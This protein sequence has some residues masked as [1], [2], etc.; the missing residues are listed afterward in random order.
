MRT[1]AAGPSP[2]DQ[3]PEAP[4]IPHDAGSSGTFAYGRDTPVE[5]RPEPS[6]WSY[7][8]RLSV[9]GWLVFSG[10]LD[11]YIVFQDQDAIRVLGNGP[12]L[13]NL[14]VAALVAWLLIK[15][16]LT[17]GAYAGRAALLFYACL[18]VVGANAA[19][20]LLSLALLVI[21]LAHHQP[22]RLVLL[23]LL[24]QLPAA[25]LFWWMVEGLRRF[26]PWAARRV[27]A[28]PA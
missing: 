5:F 10:L 15:A 11:A 8:M 26:G 1:D 27:P 22:A 2:L 13:F 24:V 6:E 17:V 23:S 20:V 18:A 12:G 7:P 19:L 14:A 25:G 28:T 4:G 9:A 16:F 21:D 3:V